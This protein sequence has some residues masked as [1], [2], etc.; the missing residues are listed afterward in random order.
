MC[1]ARTS[2]LQV[3]FSSLFLLVGL[4]VAA[5]ENLTFQD[6]RLLE[7]SGDLSAVAEEYR[8]WLGEN[9]GSEDFV[10]A[11]V[12]YADVEPDPRFAVEVMNGYLPRLSGD[13]KA[14]IATKIALLEEMRGDTEHAAEAYEIAYLAN[15]SLEALVS[16]MR[17]LLEH[18][19]Y[20][21][22]EQTL[23][24]LLD[25]AEKHKTV[26]KRARVLLGQLYA[27][28]GRHG[29]AEVHLEIA[30]RS[31]DYEE[32]Q[33]L[34]GMYGLFL[35]TGRPEKASE[36]LAELTD[37]FAEAPETQ[38]ATGS[39][40]VSL[41]PTPPKTLLDALRKATASPPAE[42]RAVSTE[43][44]GSY[45]IQIGSY[46][47]F[48]NAKHMAVGVSASGFQARVLEVHID[49]ITYYRVV[50]AESFTEQSAED[51]LLRLKE[52]GFEGMR[53]AASRP[54]SPP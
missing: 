6:L 46:R 31:D 22:V 43:I 42:V 17:I 21:T 26:D 24:A 38:L 45:G 50:L 39:T 11:L 25:G 32:T 34:Y 7:E 40:L 8:R 4:L 10:A 23:L 15:G 36:V 33:A 20:V 51:V 5:G 29:E 12:R 41:S 19:E 1:P 9:S 3:C 52:A 2:G 49:S 28:Q 27:L 13:Q 14:D 30:A 35:D 48:D 53:V 37:R 44:D 47:V 18:G 16:Q 54:E